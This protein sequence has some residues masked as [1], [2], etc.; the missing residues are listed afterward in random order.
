MIRGSH[1]FYYNNYKV[2]LSCNAAGQELIKIKNK[3]KN[4]K[5]ACNKKKTLYRTVHL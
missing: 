1:N 2:L 5:K 3:N 4:T